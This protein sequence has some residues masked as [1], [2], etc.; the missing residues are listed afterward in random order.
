MR[1]ASEYNLVIYGLTRATVLA[2][3]PAA[4]TAIL[5][6]S[7]LQLPLEE[8]DCSRGALRRGASALVASTHPQVV[9]GGC[10]LASMMGLL[11]CT[12]PLGFFE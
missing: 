10:V 6:L 1:W 9:P 11:K 7:L 3:P 5:M 12:D 2:P 8:D 4:A